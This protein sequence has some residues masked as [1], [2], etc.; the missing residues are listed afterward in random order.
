MEAARARDSAAADALDELLEL[1]GLPPREI[2]VDTSPVLRNTGE[3]QRLLVAFYPADL[4][5]A[6][7]GGR[8][9]V[10]LNVNESGVVQRRTLNTSS[11]NEALD[12]AALAVARGMRFEPA[13]TDDRPQA[14]WVSQWFTFE[15]K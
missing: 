12:R 5:A 10:W 9:E 1:A 15:A 2:P 8:V 14:V 3:V 6:G 13:T 11:G 7:I 4:R